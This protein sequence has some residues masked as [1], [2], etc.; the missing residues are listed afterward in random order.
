MNRLN[1][2]GLLVVLAAFV[3]SSLACSMM[4][5]PS[6]SNEFPV[7]IVDDFG[8]QVTI[9]REPQCIICQG[10]SCTEIVY[11]LGALDKVVA[12]DPYSDYPPEVAE[13]PKI[14]ASGLGYIKLSA[15]AEDFETLDPDL[16]ITYSYVEE[17]EADD[18]ILPRLEALGLKVIVLRPLTLEDVLSNIELVGKALGRESEASTLVQDLRVRMEMIEERVADVTYR[19]KVYIE[20]WYP[21]PWTFGPG[22]WGHQLIEMAGGA[23]AFGDAQVQWVRTS[24]EEVIERDPDVI[25]SLRGAMHQATLEDFRARP[26]WGQVRAVQQG[27]VYVVDEN[28]FLRPGPRLIEG[29]EVLA[30]ILHPEIFGS[31]EVVAT[32]VDVGAVNRGLA[33]TLSGVAESFNFTLLVTEAAAPSNFTLKT[34][35]IKVG[36]SPP[37]GL[38]AVG[39]YL[40][41]HTSISG[42]AL[43]MLAVI[44]YDEAEVG[45]LGVSEETLAVYRWDGGEW[46]EVPSAAMVDED[47]VVAVVNHTSYLALMGMPSPPPPPLISTPIPLWQ[48]LM[49]GV[50]AAVAL[51]LVGFALGRRRRR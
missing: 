15:S 13:K 27:S 4:A 25:V 37:Q 24:D 5:A 33:Q 14:G 46:V 28:L 8:R 22:T 39:A 34:T 7:T 20:S 2:I 9:D 10:P 11:A 30:G 1:A 16:I 3:A 23:N 49:V 6:S 32:D 36:P 47:L 31:V 50:A 26:G 41:I 19:P 21:P 48:A 44:S 43:R 42:V 12:V 35:V 40:N 17:S 45:R 51:G 18:T 29:L 38:R